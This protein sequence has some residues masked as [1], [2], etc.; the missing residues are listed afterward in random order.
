M[1]V[2]LLTYVSNTADLCQQQNTL[3]RLAER[4]CPTHEKGCSGEMERAVLGYCFIAFPKFNTE[5]L[6]LFKLNSES[7]FVK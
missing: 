4:S 1:S 2:M 7:T 5:L 3:S 6:F